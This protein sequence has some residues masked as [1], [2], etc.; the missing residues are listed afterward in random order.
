[1]MLEEFFKKVS[2]FDGFHADKYKHWT[3]LFS[4]H[5]L[6][7]IIQSKNIIIIHHYSCKKIIY[8]N[9]LVNRHWLLL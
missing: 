8:K 5:Y 1:M 6:H 7:G 4:L 9:D 2:C 3:I